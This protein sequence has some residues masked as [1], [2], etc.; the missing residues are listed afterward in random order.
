VAG[1]DGDPRQGIEHP[2]ASALRAQPLDE[3]RE[4]VVKDM[5]EV[6]GLEYVE[7][8]RERLWSYN[9]RFSRKQ[10]EEGLPLFIDASDVHGN[11]DE[12]CQD[13]YDNR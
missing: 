10:I 1:V 7:I 9:I 13:G 2:L 8:V 12:W 11:V 3:N 5:R 6:V 4:Q